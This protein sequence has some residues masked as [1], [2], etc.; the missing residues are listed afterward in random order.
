MEFGGCCQQQTHSLADAGHV[1][2]EQLHLVH[3]QIVDLRLA[4]GPLDPAHANLQT[5]RW[6][7]ANADDQQQAGRN[8]HAGDPPEPAPKPLPALDRY[9]G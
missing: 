9:R 8:P 5:Y 2:G 7:K 3:R 6:D 4:L 1:C